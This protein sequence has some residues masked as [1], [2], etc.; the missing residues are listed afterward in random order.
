MSQR[1][2]GGRVRPAGPVM[3]LCPPGPGAPPPGGLPA[4]GRGGASPPAGARIGRAGAERDTHHLKPDLIIFSPSDPKPA[5]SPHQMHRKGKG[6]RVA[7]SS[8]FR[9][10]RLPIPYVYVLYIETVF[11]YS[12]C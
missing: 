5:L 2:R 4:P 6:E 11:R 10:N 1:C 7:E 12:R 3:G 9:N 8:A